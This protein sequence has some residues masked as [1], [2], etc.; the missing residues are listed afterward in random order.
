MNVSE[1]LLQ[2]LNFEHMT[3]GGAFVE[4]FYPWI[5]TVKRWRKEGLPEKFTEAYLYPK[6][7]DRSRRYFNDLMTEQIY[8]YEQFFGFDGV[9]RMS[10]RIPFKCFDKDILEDTDEYM[11]RIDEDEENIINPV[12]RFM[13]CVL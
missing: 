9:K 7:V 13:R 3:E 1:R 12:T 10:F 8:E 5:L 11:V 4:T 6:A 2:T